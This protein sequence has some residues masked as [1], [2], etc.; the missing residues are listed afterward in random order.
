METSLITVLIGG[1]II[2]IISFCAG[3]LVSRGVVLKARRGKRKAELNM[4]KSEAE[5]LEYIKMQVEEA[6]RN[7]LSHHWRQ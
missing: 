7:N 3:L 5:L 4:L 1:A 6:D 2:S